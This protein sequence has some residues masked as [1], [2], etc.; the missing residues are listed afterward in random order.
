VKGSNSIRRGGGSES[1]ISSATTCEEQD[2]SLERYSLLVPKERDYCRAS[3]G[4]F[5]FVQA[6]FKMKGE[7]SI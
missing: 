5:K 4:K 3:W 7:A 6:G 2:R 1:I